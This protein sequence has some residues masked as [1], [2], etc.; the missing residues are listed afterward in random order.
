MII[1]NFVFQVLAAAIARIMFIHINEGVLLINGAKF[2]T[3]KTLS[4]GYFRRT[5]GNSSPNNIYNLRTPFAPYL[6]WSGNW[7]FGV[8]YRIRCEQLGL[9]CQKNVTY[10]DLIAEDFILK[11]WILIPHYVNGGRDKGV[12]FFKIIPQNI[13]AKYHPQSDNKEHPIFDGQNLPQ[14]LQTWIDKTIKEAKG[15]I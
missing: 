13:I 6:A 2:Y 11:G 3:Y 4:F 7:D 15:L 12:D 1:A 14:N 8:T 5:L 9:V 10:A